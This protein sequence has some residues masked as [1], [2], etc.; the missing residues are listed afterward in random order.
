M[1]STFS[2]SHGSGGVACFFAAALALFAGGGV[3]T[4]GG[5]NPGGLGGGGGRLA[6][7]A[8]SNL[9][10]RRPRCTFEPL[11]VDQHWSLTVHGTS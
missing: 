6:P 11:I 3:G 8:M 4:Y 5:N 2:G 7:D 1:S 9:V 10:G